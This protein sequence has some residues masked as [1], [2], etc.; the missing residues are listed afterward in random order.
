MQLKKTLFTGL[1]LLVIAHIAAFGQAGDEKKA[2]EYLANRNFEQALEEYLL[3]IEETPHD[4]EY[5]YNVGVCFLNT[6][7]D[8]SNAVK[9]FE[10]AKD[11]GYDD[12]NLNYTLG[13]A[14]HVDAQFDK[15]NSSFKNCNCIIYII[16]F[17]LFSCII[18]F[19]MQ[20]FV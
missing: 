8:K 7:I 12:N 1:F 3:L 10:A 16:F 18:K 19:K 17:Y 14:Y 11:L 9:Y 5:N 13:M 20:P 4:A 2:K 6:N 15:A